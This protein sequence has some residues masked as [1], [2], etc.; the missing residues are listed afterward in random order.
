MF[1]EALG[2]GLGQEGLERVGGKAKH[3]LGSGLQLRCALGVHLVRCWGAQG[4]GVKGFA[5]S[6][7]RMQGICATFLLAVSS[8]WGI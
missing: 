6:F 1:K 8:F 5:D 3:Q 7:V 4:A 2:E